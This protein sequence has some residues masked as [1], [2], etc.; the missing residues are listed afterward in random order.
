L[1]SRR[2]SDGGFGDDGGEEE[3]VVSCLFELRLNGFCH[4]LR[5]GFS[6]V[7]ATIELRV[8]E[9]RAKRGLCGMDENPKCPATPSSSK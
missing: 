1:E 6:S 4:V 7:L 8:N 9:N 3:E 5:V 2:S